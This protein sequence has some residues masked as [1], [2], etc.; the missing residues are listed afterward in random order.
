HFV[1]LAQEFQRVLE[2]SI[3]FDALGH[4]DARRQQL[5]QRRRCFCLLGGLLGRGLLTLLLFLGG[6][7]AG[8]VPDQAHACEEEQQ[9]PA[10]GGSKHGSD[11][12]EEN[13]EYP[14]A[15]SAS[16]GRPRSPPL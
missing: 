10:N 11:S 14:P 13:T 1:F 3:L 12:R 15:R 8:R 4:V 6:G 9:A 5:F 2:L 7:G 16:K